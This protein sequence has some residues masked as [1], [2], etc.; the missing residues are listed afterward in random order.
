ME[1]IIEWVQSQIHISHHLA[2][3]PQDSHKDKTVDIKVLL[4]TSEYHSKRVEKFKS[5][6]KILKAEQHDPQGNL[7]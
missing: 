4:S 3:Y 6:L 2:S 1:E 5:A 7:P